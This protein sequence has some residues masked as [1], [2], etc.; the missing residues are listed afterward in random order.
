MY[1]NDISPFKKE[2]FY[3][4]LYSND[5]MINATCWSYTMPNVVPDFFGWLENSTYEGQCW[6]NN[7]IEGN[8]WNSTTPFSENSINPGVKEQKLQNTF[9]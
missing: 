6:S 2:L 7:G 8:L 5:Q 1:W 3:D 9:C 4:I